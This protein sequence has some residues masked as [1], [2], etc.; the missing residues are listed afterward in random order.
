M[1]QLPTCLYLCYDRSKPIFGCKLTSNECIASVYLQ[2]TKDESDKR[3]K[4]YQIGFGGQDSISSRFS[5]RI[6]EHLCPG[7]ALPKEIA[8]KVREFKETHKKS[9]EHSP[10]HNI[11]EIKD[12]TRKID[13]QEDFS[14]F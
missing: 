6:A 12:L 2:I 5:E 3:K 10:L 1:C 13:E 14:K 9:F 8:E 7:Y 11:F 4:S